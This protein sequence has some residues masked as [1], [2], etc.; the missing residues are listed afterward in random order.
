M[1]M[2]KNIMSK[3]KYYIISALV[4][5]VILTLFLIFTSEGPQEGAFR[6]QIF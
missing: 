5:L 1:T 3:Y 6:Y 2:I 4:I